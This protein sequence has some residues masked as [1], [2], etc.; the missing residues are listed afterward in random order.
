MTTVL[1][2]SPRRPGGG[3]TPRRLARLRRLGVQA[4]IQRLVSPDRFKNHAHDT[5]A[6][7]AT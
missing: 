7:Q 4:V 1:K 6:T 3:P 5:S 2:V